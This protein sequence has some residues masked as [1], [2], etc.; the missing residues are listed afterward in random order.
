MRSCALGQVCAEVVRVTIW[1][2]SVRDLCGG[3]CGWAQTQNVAQAAL[4]AGNS[5]QLIFKHSRKLVT[6]QD[7][8]KWFP[9]YPQAIGIKEGSLQLTP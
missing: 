8:E 9:I 5:P 7:V 2:F 4:E 3:I 6:P 1:P